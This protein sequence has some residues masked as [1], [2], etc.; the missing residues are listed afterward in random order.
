MALRRP[1]QLQDAPGPG[2]LHHGGHTTPP[3]LVTLASSLRPVAWSALRSDVVVRQ[4][5]D[6]DGACEVDVGF[7]PTDALQGRRRSRSIDRAANRFDLALI[8]HRLWVAPVPGDVTQD[9]GSDHSARH[10]GRR[11]APE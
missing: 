3:P 11:A 9:A 2:W 7:D 4:E 10:A 8:G 6:A 5:A 1:A